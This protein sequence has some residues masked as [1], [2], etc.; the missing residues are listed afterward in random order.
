MNQNC[1]NQGNMGMMRGGCM[2]NSMNR[3]GYGMNHGTDGQRRYDNR[4]MNA[5]MSC[6]SRQINEQRNSDGSREMTERR[7]CDSNC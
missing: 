2:R 1:N 4:S 7:G 3:Q 5:G 6:S